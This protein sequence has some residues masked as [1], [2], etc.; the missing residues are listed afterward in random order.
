MAQKHKT[1]K[2]SGMVLP[3]L[4]HVDAYAMIVDLNHYTNMVRS[5]E[6]V[7]DVIAQFTRDALSGAADAVEKHGGEV[8]GFMGDAFLGILPDDESTMYTCFS[9]AKD[10]DGQCE[11]ISDAQADSDDLWA[12]APGGPSLKIAIEYGTLDISTIY[13]RLLG[14]QR[15]FAGNAINHANRILAAGKGNR[16][17]VGP[18]AAKRA[19]SSYS[20]DGPHYIRGKQGE[21]KYEYYFFS[22]GDIWIEGPRRKGKD[23]YW[24]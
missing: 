21:P 24:G 5:A 18:V 12:F 10:V 16:C 19:F 17:N 3:K 9:I 23:T 7:G 15:L 20:L 4:G 8:V 1:P 22:M 13:S 14:E 2:K 6:Q 11:Y